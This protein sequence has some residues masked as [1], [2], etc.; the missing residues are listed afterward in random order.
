MHGQ[1]RLALVHGEPEAAAR[2]LQS[3]RGRE[4]LDEVGDRDVDA[5]LD[6]GAKP[7]LSNSYWRAFTSTFD[8]RPLLS[9]R[10]RRAGGRSSGVPSENPAFDWK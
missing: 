10:S 4:F 1:A 7:D 6:G 8:R 2:R 9:Y 3:G 5:V